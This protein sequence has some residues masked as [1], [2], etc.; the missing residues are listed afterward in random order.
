MEGI[1]NCI[2]LSSSDVYG[3]V[4]PPFREIQRVLPAS[5]YSV[6]K[7]SS[8]MYCLMFSKVYNFPITILRGF[9]LFGKY[10][11]PNRVI[12]FII[13]ELLQEREV[14]L[15]EGKQK[16]EFNYVDNLIDAIFLSLLNPNGQGE[17]IN[18]G[19]GE[20]FSIREIAL[21]IGQTLNRVDQIKFGAIPYRPNEIWDMYCDN[22]KAKKLLEWE[23]RI[24]LEEGIE[25]TLK[26]FQTLFPKSSPS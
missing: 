11:R 15:T 6:S 19:C 9:N 21:N 18:I 14:K 23:P 17:I 8:E 4:T 13:S 24:T 2:F 26:W 12:P 5:P 20:S 16:R 22:S 3:E 25:I 10:Q 1:T 7:A